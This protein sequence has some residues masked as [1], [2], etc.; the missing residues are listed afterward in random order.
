MTKNERQQ[1]LINARRACLLLAEYAAG[2]SMLILGEPQRECVGSLLEEFGRL[3]A[4]ERR[5]AEEGN[6]GAAYGHLG[7]RPPKK[8]KKTKL[9]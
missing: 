8:R 3:D 2:E 9:S 1:S 5:Q 6:K 4:K 7:G